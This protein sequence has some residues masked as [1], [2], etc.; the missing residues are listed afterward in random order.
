MTPSWSKNGLLS[1]ASF[2]FRNHRLNLRLCISFSVPP[3]SKLV[4]I[5]MQVQ[6]CVWNGTRRRGFKS[7]SRINHQNVHPLKCLIL[8]ASHGHYKAKADSSICVIMIQFSHY[9][10]SKINSEFALQKLFHYTVQKKKKT[11]WKNE[12]W[13]QRRRPDLA[14]DDF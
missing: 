13:Q 10:T 2:V 7:N 12:M 11:K 14:A 3:A 9:F 6:Q 1:A 4:T 5:Q 8:S